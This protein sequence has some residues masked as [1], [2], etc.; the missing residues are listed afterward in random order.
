[1]RLARYIAILV[2]AAAAPALVAAA[3]ASFDDNAKFIAG[4]KP[5]ENSPLTPLTKQ[6]GWQ[7]HAAFFD[8]TWRSHDQ[9]QMSRV[10]SW[11]EKN[12]ENP[13]PTL[14]YLF[15]G[16][17]FLYADAFFPKATTYVLAGLEP[18][19]PIPD[20]LSLPQ[21]S[22]PSELRNIQASLSTLLRYSFFITKNMRVQF[23]QSR[24]TGVMPALYVFLARSGKTITDVSLVEVDKDGAVQPV[25]PAPGN[26]KGVKITFTSAGETAPRTLYYFSTDLSN[27][28]L[29]RS[30]FAAFC[31]KTGT[32]N[33]FLKSAS[34]LLHSGNFS[35]VRDLLLKQ[36]VSILQDDSGIPVRYF[37][38]NAWEVRPFG[39][40]TGPI[41]IF[42]QNYQQQLED[43]Y[44][45]E[46]PAPLEFGIGYRIRA[47]QSSLVLAVKKAVQANANPSR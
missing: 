33:A 35:S 41:A 31:E 40:Y 42:A 4:M 44:R 22:V 25:S 23:A 19:G 5:A 38:Q 34:Y 30:G 29:K 16:P 32:G 14:F 39:R 21:A 37:E 7:D 46:R 36:S 43:I 1:M 15:S 27:D 26:A 18:V 24:L 28:G 6:G 17:D 3:P 11:S 13:S 2:F 10:R 8:R 9:A 20:V 45:K 12:I 47:P